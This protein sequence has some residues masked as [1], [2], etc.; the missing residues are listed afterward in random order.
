METVLEKTT[1]K[2]TYCR[3][4]A[5]EFFATFPKEKI[6]AYKEYWEGV[7]PQ[8]H[9][10]IFRRYLFAYCS[11]HTSWKGNCYGYNAIKNYEE[12]I[13]NKETLREKLAG[14]GVG[15]HNN[16][17]KYIWDFAAQFWANPKDFYLTTKKYHVKKRDEI[18]NKIM[19][20][21][22]AKVSFAL[23]MIHPNEART[24]CLDVHMLRLYGMEHLTY[25]K[26]KEGISKYKRAERH[27][28][29]NCGKLKTP[30]YIARCAYWDHLQGKDD[31]RYW[32]YVLEA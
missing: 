2:T 17:T 12:W 23:E 10:D 4:R 30:S 26:S 28:M 22:M 8:N 1:K 25:T 32:S 15:L 27:W 9:G 18:V 19:G 5:D 21:G 20:L 3:S 7:R 31:S 11:V 6:S 14:S 29:V 13:D 24:L 16:R